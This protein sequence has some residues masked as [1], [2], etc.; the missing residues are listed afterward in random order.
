MTDSLYARWGFIAIATVSLLLTVIV[1]DAYVPVTETVAKDFHAPIN[2][3]QL[4][5]V[6]LIAIQGVSMPLL[7]RFGDQS[8][9]VPVLLSGILIFLAGC[10][11]CLLAPLQWLFYSGRILQ[12]IGASAILVIVPALIRDRYSDN[13]TARQFSI[14]AATLLLARVVS[15]ELG[16]GIT[17]HFGW[18]ALF[19]VFA[20]LALLVLLVNFFYFRK[21]SLY[22]QA[23]ASESFLQ[24]VL[25]VFRHRVSMQWLLINGSTSVVVLVYINNAS[26]LF[27]EYYGVSD[28]YLAYSLSAAFVI[29]GLSALAN[30][31][32]LRRYSYVWVL[33][34]A[35]M[36]LLVI[37]V[38]NML[39]DWTASH[40]LLS[41]TLMLSAMFF[42]TGFIGPNAVAGMVQNHPDAAAT[43]SS[44]LDVSAIIASSLVS[45][46]VVS[47]A[48]GT[49][50]I[51]SLTT[52][53]VVM[54]TGLLIF[55]LK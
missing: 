8:G 26:Y 45:V 25:R 6:L 18:R 36:A 29:Q 41:N 50:K 38:L 55:K 27:S 19:V 17:E 37:S 35:F 21:E 10:L 47:L 49:P 7:A 15:P 31:L 28:G 48:D 52:A 9:R 16:V 30:I 40:S 24:V 3:F 46:L 12:G 22:H 11:L 23:D 43:A 5:T 42:C 4:T 44:V 13:E 14:I 1:E 53:G 20:G 51:L 39:F 33:N 54:L 2:H 32:L 34:K